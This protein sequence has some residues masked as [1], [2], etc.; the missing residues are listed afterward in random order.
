MYLKTHLKLSGLKRN[1]DKMSLFDGL[2]EAINASK[3]T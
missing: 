2:T 3:S 1:S